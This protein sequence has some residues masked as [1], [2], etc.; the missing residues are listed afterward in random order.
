MPTQLFISGKNWKLSLAEL[1]TYFQARQETFQTVFVSKEFF[2]FDLEQKIGAIEDLGGTIKIADVQTE[3]PTEAARLAFLEKNKQAQAQITEQI[4]LSGIVDE[5]EKNAT[6]EKAF[7][8]VSVYCA[9]KQFRQLS[10]QIQRTVG[11]II[12]KELAS[13]GKKSQFMGFSKE[14]RAAQLSHVEVLKKNLIESRGEVLFCVGK[15]KVWVAITTAVHNPFEFQKRDVYKPRQRVIYGMPPRLARIMLNLSHCKEGKVVLDPFCGV[16]TVL[17]EALLAKAEAVGLDINTW[18]VNA[19]TENLEWIRQ[20]YDLPNAK[21]RVI[22][23]NVGNLTSKVGFENVDCIVT[24]PDLGPPLKQIPTTP[25]AHKVINKLDPLFSGFVREAFNVLREGGRLVLVTPYIVSRS[26]DIVTMNIA[27]KAQ[28][29]GFTVVAP[30]GKE[31]FG[32]SAF[33]EKNLG[34]LSSLVETDERHKI[35][36]EIHIFQKINLY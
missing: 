30:F 18:C 19:A 21:F 27:Q 2:V 9:D 26:G 24:E 14:R 12:K 1:I 13:A 4:S 17:Q 7:F 23:G 35:G 28:E 34:E 16:G 29:A 25:Y 36:R 6:D 3:F 32:D 20:E 11:S 10:G 22:V 31:M 5:I 33:L 8:G 15:E